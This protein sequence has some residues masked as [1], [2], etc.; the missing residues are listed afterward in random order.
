[1]ATPMLSRVK[2]ADNMREFSWG[3]GEDDWAY[4]LSLDGH[5]FPRS[6]MQVAAELLRYSAPNS[7]ERALQL[8]TP[9]YAKRDGYCF[10]QP[11]MLNIPLNK[12][13]NENDNIS[14]DVSPEYLLEQWNK[15][16][17]LDYINLENRV[18]NSVHQELEVTF[19]RRSAVDM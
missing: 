13:Q 11:K 9:L 1:M 4:Q 16:M 2:G 14:A 5:I 7:F 3:D 15:G 6:E 18:S 10:A 12:V 8:L 19:C 17:M